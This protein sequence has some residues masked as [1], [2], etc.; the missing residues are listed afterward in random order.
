MNPFKRIQEEYD[1]SLEEIRNSETSN[2]RSYI[3]SI[4]K[5]MQVKKEASNLYNQ[6]RNDSIPMNIPQLQPQQPQYAHQ[7]APPQY[8]MAYPQLYNQDAYVQNSATTFKPI[9]PRP[10]IFINDIFTGVGDSNMSSV[11]N[12][13]DEQ[14]RPQNQHGSLPSR[15]PGKCINS[16]FSNKI[17][18]TQFRSGDDVVS[19]QAD[20][21]NVYQ[22]NNGNQ[23]NAPICASPQIFDQSMEP[24]WL[25]QNAP[26][27]GT[28]TKE[29]YQQ[30]VAAEFY[31]QEQARKNNF[32]NYF[33]SPMN[34]PNNPVW[35]PMD[36]KYLN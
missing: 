22:F 27:L 19:M 14:A 26:T 17:N 7:F 18:Q 28:I 16:S 9:P 36:S 4:D 13:I 21:G 12:V 31:K 33:N 25:P 34:N 5:F 3:N 23:S 20:N 15:S 24:K 32:M 35:K 6:M 29:Q 11:R 1:N 30:S 8:N 2:E 10:S